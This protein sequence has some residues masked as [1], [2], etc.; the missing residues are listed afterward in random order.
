VVRTM[1]LDRR[2]G[3]ATIFLEGAIDLDTAPAVGTVVADCLSR[4]IGRT[5]V[6]LTGTTFLLATP[7]IE[8][9]SHPGGFPPT[10]PAPRR[11]VASGDQ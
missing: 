1:T 7:S 5:E 9:P 6:D 11:P 4:G 2:Q 10:T 3:R 8:P